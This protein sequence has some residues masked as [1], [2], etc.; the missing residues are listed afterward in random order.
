MSDD[1]DAYHK[2]LGIP[3]QE[4]PPN[5]YRLLG[6]ALFES[7]AD[8]ISNAAD[9]RMAHVRTFQ[10]GARALLSQRILNEIA[11]ARVTL[12]NPEKKAAYD[13]QLR[14]FLA[15]SS[16]RPGGLGGTNELA[17]LDTTAAS[18]AAE[19]PVNQTPTALPPP[20]AP[21]Q[22]PSVALPQP[23]AHGKPGAPIAEPLVIPAGQPNA[24]AAPSATTETPARQ[25]HLDQQMAELL[26]SA[27]QDARA[28]EALFRKLLQRKH[29]LQLRL[30]LVYL[31]IAHA[32]ILLL[33]RKWAEK[34]PLQRQGTLIIGLGLAAAVCT[35]A[36]ISLT[37]ALVYVAGAAFAGACSAALV[38]VH[39]LFIPSDQMLHQSL[40]SARNKPPLLRA[41]LH[42]AAADCAQARE[43]YRRALQRYEQLKKTVPG[44]GQS[45][46][47]RA[48]SSGR[49]NPD[50][51]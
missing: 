26:R 14:A 16:A 38:A 12:L 9:Q 7:D 36:A 43:A 45:D 10:T 22:L 35:V 21:A 1:F 24:E 51:A 6:I 18:K 15:G 44:I 31:Q 8:V 48:A 3:P 23:S 32:E 19:L 17:L 50:V 28:A 2:W 46:G 30:L 4:Q 47:A 39:V 42:R 49:Q 20:D 11:A 13:Q 33:A 27:E 37:N 40:S 25:Q 41:E 34:M 29:Q 5:Y